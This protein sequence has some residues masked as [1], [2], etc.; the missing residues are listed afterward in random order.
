MKRKSRG[1]GQGCAIKLKENN[2]QCIVT[3]GFDENGKRI[4]RYKSGFYCKSDALAYAQTLK[5][6]PEE[7]KPIT[8]YDGYKK[9]METFTASKSTMLCYQ[10]GFNVLKPLWRVNINDQSIDRLQKCIDDCGLGVRTK[11][12]A[13][14]ILGLIYKWAIPRG[15]VDNKVNLAEFI[16]IKS[17]DDDK[18]QKVGFTA[19]QMQMLKDAAETDKVAKIVL[20]NCY[21]GFRPQEIIDITLADYDDKNK[22]FKGGIKTDAGKNRTVTVSPKIQPLVDALIDDARQ[23]GLAKDQTY[24]FTKSGR[25]STTKQYRKLFYEL[26]DRIGIEN[27]EHNIT[28][29]SCRHTFATM[30]KRIPGA[31]EKDVLELIGHS[32]IAMTQYYQDVS[33]EDLRNITDKM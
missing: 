6:L 9:Y 15:Y 10:A 19:E 27:D 18:P 5:G 1:N 14:T 8:L 23:N 3:I 7:K 17:T 21:L 29:H 12:N 11:Q 28:P 31:A 33:V 30:I 13:K 32:D 25:K 2:W 26:L 20:C 24:P 16:K 4:R 22:T